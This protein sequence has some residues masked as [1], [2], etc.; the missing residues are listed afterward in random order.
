MEYS[1]MVHIIYGRTK[2]EAYMLLKENPGIS[3][4]FLQE[5]FTVLFVQRKLQLLPVQ[6]TLFDQ[7]K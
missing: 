5:K 2:E 6:T 4:K 1:V 7:P 3:S